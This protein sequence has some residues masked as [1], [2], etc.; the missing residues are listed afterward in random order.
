MCVSWERNPLEERGQRNKQETRRQEKNKKKDD[1]EWGKQDIHSLTMIN[2]SSMIL[3]PSWLKDCLQRRKEI[4]F[5]KNTINMKSILS[6]V[7]LSWCCSWCLVLSISFLRREHPLLPFNSVD[8]LLHL[9]LFFFPDVCSLIF[10]L[11]ISMNC[12]PFSVNQ[13][14]CQAFVFRFLSFP[15]I[16][17]KL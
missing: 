15:F 9:P 4:L 7:F 5:L 6:H 17:Q 3:M 14:W 12:M 13:V 2:F 11:R 1:E 8:G 10:R 16:Y